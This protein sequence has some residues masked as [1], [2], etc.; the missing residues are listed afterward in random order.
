MILKP[1]TLEEMHAQLSTL[2]EEQRRVIVTV[3]R[4]PNEGTLNLALHHHKSWEQHG[5]IV[6]QIPPTWTPHG[7][8]KK[9]LNDVMKRKSLPRQIYEKLYLRFKKQPTKKITEELNAEI[10]KLAH[11]PGD[12]EITEYLDENGIKVP[13][14]HFHSTMRGPQHGTGLTISVSRWGSKIHRVVN[15]TP[16][17]KMY[18]INFPLHPA[19]V[20][21]EYSCAGKV[22]KSGKSLKFFANTKRSG[23]GQVNASYLPGGDEVGSS[24]ITKKA[25]VDFEKEH[26]NTF[27][28]LLAHLSKTGLKQNK[29]T[30]SY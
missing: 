4:H 19:D 28:M 22:P 20:L 30:S 13:V 7:S 9:I 16:S 25:I 2:P 6:V 12:S 11:I 10:K 21:V 24:V 8:Y 15:L 1:K 5:A 14:V 18:L 23:H 27:N 29:P 3:G 17:T 26:A